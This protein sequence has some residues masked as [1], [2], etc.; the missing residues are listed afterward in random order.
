MR[1]LLYKEMTLSIHKFFYVLPIMLSFLFFI[2]NWFFSLVAMYFFWISVSNIYSTYNAQLDYHFINMLPVTKQDVVLSKSFAFILLE[3]FHI[4][5]AVIF[6][7]IHNMIYGSFNFA[8]DINPAFFGI[9]FMTFGIFNIIFLPQYF[10]T[11]Y[12]FGKP[13]IYGVTA[14][15][16][17]AGFFEYSSLK[18]KYVNDIIENNNT[19]LQLGILCFGII[20]FVILNFIGI[21]KA[22]VNYVRI[23]Q[24]T[25]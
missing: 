1:N 5:L 16:L 4:I 10:K 15:L 3:I 14:T 20:V 25:T 18:I 21:K 2:P 22:I 7:V 19:M 9:M 23:N 6:G 24:W 11:A 13:V 12:K 17:F 8:M